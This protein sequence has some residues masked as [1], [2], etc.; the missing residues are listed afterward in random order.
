MVGSGVAVQSGVEKVSVFPEISSS[1]DV[2]T[3]EVVAVGA[4]SAA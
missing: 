4:E 2:I 3:G 1:C